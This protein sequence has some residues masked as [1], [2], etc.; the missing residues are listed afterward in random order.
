MET[1]P[2][3]QGDRRAFL[4][5]L[6]TAPLALSGVGFFTSAIKAQAQAAGL[7]AA[8]VC[9]IAPQTT[10]GPY[11]LDTGLVRSE[12]AEDRAGVGLRMALQVVRGDCTPLPGARVDLW[13]CDAT[14]RY[15]GTGD[16]AGETFLRGTQMADANG[17]VAFDTIFP[18]WYPGRAVHMHYKV[19]LNESEAVTSQAFFPE[20]LARV[21]FRNE[22]P[23]AAR[24]LPD[25]PNT[26]D[27]IARRAGEGAFAAVTEVAPGRY[28]GSLVVGVDT[29]SA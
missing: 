16:A 19:W 18:G 15:S 24:G 12:I 27:G 9:M 3:P 28:Q 26:R 14:G 29:D 4:R 13:H 7:I 21:I 5:A 22:E 10:E 11:Y 2:E 17:V 25:M 1:A 8:N 23:Y 6:A 20:A